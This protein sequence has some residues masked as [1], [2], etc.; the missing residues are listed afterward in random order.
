[1]L[2]FKQQNYS[3]AAQQLA[4]AADLGLNEARLF[5]FLGICYDRTNRVQQA[6]STYKHALELDD[7]LPE[8]HLNL[9]YTYHRQGREALAT[10]EYKRACELKQDFCKLV[11]SGKAE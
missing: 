3:Q 2:Y 11:G 9:G 5:N 4:K 7:S 8:A 1:M 6:V 10:R